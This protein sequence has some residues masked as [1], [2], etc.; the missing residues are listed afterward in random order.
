MKAFWKDT[1]EQV[2]MIENLGKGLRGWEYS[3][4]LATKT[5]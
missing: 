1:R 4:H 3:D 2:T 5:S